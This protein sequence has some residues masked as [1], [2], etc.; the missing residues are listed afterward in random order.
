MCLCRYRHDSVYSIEESDNEHIKL[1][2][3]RQECGA[4]SAD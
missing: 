2:I 3:T 4:L 1:N